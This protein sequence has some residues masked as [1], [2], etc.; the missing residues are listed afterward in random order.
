MQRFSNGARILFRPP[1]IDYTT[2]KEEKLKQA[3]LDKAN[4]DVEKKEKSS[5][6]ISPEAELLEETGGVKILA[7]KLKKPLPL[8]GGLE[9]IVDTIPSNRVRIRRCNM[10]AQTV[11]KEESE[12]ILLKAILRGIR[13]L[14]NDYRIISERK[15]R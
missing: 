5:G 4:T 3:A 1:S 11:I 9:I 13:I 6:Y 10:G 2:S 12:K 7:P 15:M 8:E 14:E